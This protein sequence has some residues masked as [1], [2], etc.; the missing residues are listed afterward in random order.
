[1]N[2]K[3]QC[4][5]LWLVT[6]PVRPPRR[7]ASRPS[8]AAAGSTRPPRRG[9]LAARLPQASELLTTSGRLK[10]RPGLSPPGP[11]PWNAL[12]AGTGPVS[13]PLPLPRVP[14][15]PSPGTCSKACPP[16]RKGE[17]RPPPRFTAR[18]LP[19]R[20]PLPRHTHARVVLGGREQESEVM[21][22]QGSRAI[23]SL[24]GILEGG[25]SGRAGSRIGTGGEK[26]IHIYWNPGVTPGLLPTPALSARPP[27]THTHSH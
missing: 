7:C 17:A 22:G 24:L 25:A 13:A 10:I 19:I 27:H 6:P 2:I 18:K 3:F 9:L 20:P 8:A 14:L 5:D 1:M 21:C 23:P 4:G 26:D 15:G 12:G 11:R 16:T